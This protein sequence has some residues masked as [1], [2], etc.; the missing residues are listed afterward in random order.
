MRTHDFA[1]KKIVHGTTIC[2]CAAINRER[3]K[4]RATNSLVLFVILSFI[5]YS[6]FVL[7]HM[8]YAQYSIIYAVSVSLSVAT[9]Y[10]SS[11]ASFTYTFVQLYTQSRRIYLV[12]NFRSTVA[13]QTSHCTICVDATIY[14]LN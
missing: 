7:T 2:I 8:R 12:R 11:F 4:R 3:C 9:C 13:G 10:S 5:L 1:M 6:V 14:V